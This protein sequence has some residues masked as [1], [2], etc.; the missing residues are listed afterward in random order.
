MLPYSEWKDAYNKF[1]TNGV[2]GPGGVMGGSVYNGKN[3]NMSN[4]S[5]G[6]DN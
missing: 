1:G 6:G 4:W 3:S 2:S 5:G